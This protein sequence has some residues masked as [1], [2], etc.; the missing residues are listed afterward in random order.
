MHVH[1]TRLKDDLIQLF[2]CPEITRQ[3]LNVRVIDDHGHLEKGEGPGVLRDV[4]S[5]FWQ[6]IF[7]SLTLGHV[8]K[9]PSIRHDHQKH[10]WEAIGRVLLYGFK[11]AGYV[12]GCLSPV[13][14]ASCLHGEE[15]ITEADLLLSFKSYI[16]PDE[17]EVLERVLSE[18]FE[19]DDE[20]L[21]EFL[22]SYK[23]YRKPKPQNIHSLF[24]E[25]AHQ[26]II[27]KPRYIANC[28]APVLEVLKGHAN[29]ANV[30][31]LRLLFLD[32][33]PT[34][35]KVIKALDAKPTS[36]AE[37]ESLGFLKKFIKSLDAVSLKVFLKF[38]TGSDVMI[39]QT[40]SVSFN[41]VEGVGR[42]PIAHT[43][44]PT[45]ELP[46]TYQSHN[47]LAEEFTNILREKTS[48]T[49]NIV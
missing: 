47:E 25:L 3:V 36:D 35:K 24:A 31:S 15:T 44:G 18:D 33:K 22:S 13:F 20:D 1:R 34:A 41:S 28:W 19:S 26:E 30:E 29:F 21:I 23:C 38:V 42:T 39:L 2:S 9:V 4:L 27:Q 43:C 32:N 40:I 11:E 37:K 17:R 45:L 10:E 14:L 8:E 48:W 49:F 7:A 16:T 46:S 6:H 5:T 12:P